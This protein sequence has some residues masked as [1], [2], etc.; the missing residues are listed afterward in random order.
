[1]LTSDLSGTNLV[2]AIKVASSVTLITELRVR[3]E[4]EHLKKDA[5]M[6]CCIMLRAVG[7]RGH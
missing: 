5:A 1:M 3:I 7:L 4:C 6:Q 2:V